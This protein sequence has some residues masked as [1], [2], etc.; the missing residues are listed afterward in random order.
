MRTTLAAIAICA[1]MWG[2]DSRQDKRKDFMA[3]LDR[4]QSQAKA[5]Y[6]RE[7]AREKAAE[8]AGDC[9]NAD[10]TRAIVECL[11]DEISTTT[12]NFKAFTGAI[13]SI[14]SLEGADAKDT[15]FGPTGQT[16]SRDE[17]LRAFDDASSAW[18]KYSKAQC[19]AISGLYKGGTFANVAGEGCQ[20]LL[21]RSRMREMDAIYDAPLRR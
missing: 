4:L 14:L 8:K 12:E 21:L 3:D 9:P 5:A 20:L 11:G 6:E 16:P 19:D 10:N 15:V 13:R 7:M 2:Q 17:V 1:A 18:D